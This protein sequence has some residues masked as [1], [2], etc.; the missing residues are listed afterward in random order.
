M[1][2]KALHL[3]DRLDQFGSR[4]YL[5]MRPQHPSLMVW[6]FHVL[7]RDE[8]AIS[9]KEVFPFEQLTADQLATFISYLQKQGH[10]FVTPQQILAGLPSTGFYHLLT[11][12][13]G[14]Y[15][16]QWALPVLEAAQVP[17]VFHI[18][19]S[20]I[21]RHRSFWWDV[22]FREKSRKG[23]SMK[24]ILAEQNQLKKVPFDQI[25][26]VLVEKYGAV[27][28]EPLGDQDRPFMADELQAFAKHPLVYLGNHAHDHA[29][30][31]HYAPAQMRQ[32]IRKSQEYLTQLTGKA[33]A[34]I[35]YPNGESSPEAIEAATAE[36]L[37]LGL[38]GER[39]KYFL[40]D[41]LPLMALGRVTLYG[42]RQIA[43]Q[44]ETYR[45]DRSMKW[46]N[47]LAENTRF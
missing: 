10:T 5:N 37:Q 23:A 35:A 47:S 30:L 42:F 19:T 3:L 11:F 29:I 26:S 2:K 32:Q 17:A 21:E 27:A 45:S 44:V 40:A 14:Y 24:A 12:D 16:N 36:G 34:V 25:E 9:Q 1:R 8:K 43:G 15:N 13:D 46:R 33:P 4:I 41:P 18:A 38:T 22:H 31:P 20:Y 7:F 6:V 39:K 28:F